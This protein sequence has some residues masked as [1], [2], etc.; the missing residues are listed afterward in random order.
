MFEH[1]LD[2]EDVRAARALER[3]YIAR[4]IAQYEARTGTD[5]SE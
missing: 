4:W 1:E 2:A 5:A 3:R